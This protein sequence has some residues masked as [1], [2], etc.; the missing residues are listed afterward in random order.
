MDPI[1]KKISKV[2]IV[3][4]NLK[5]TLEQ[6]YY[7]YGIGGWNI[8]EQNPCSMKGQVIYGIKA[9]YSA[10][11]AH[12]KIGD[13]V[14][15]LIEPSD[16]NSIYAQFLQKY[17]EGIHHLG[18]EV[19][20][21][22]KTLK[23]FENNNLK[24]T[25]S[26]YWG[27]L[28]S[29]FFN[30]KEDLKHTVE[31]YNIS[32]DFKYPKPV[33]RYPDNSI[34]DASIKPMFKEV[35]Q[36]GLAVLDIKQTART[37]NDKYGIGPWELYKYFSPKAKDMQ[38]GE[39]NINNQKF[40]T[41]A[42]MIDKIEVELVEPEQGKTVYADYINIYGEGVQHISFIYNCSFNEAIEFHKNNGQIIKQSGSINNAI[43]AYFD[44]EKDL[45]F[46]SEYVYVPQDFKMPSS[47][48]SYPG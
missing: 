46:I 26:S 39:L 45:K 24:V 21:I 11:I 29:V 13:T 38:Y 8:W 22:D 35:R 19:E 18:Y 10:Y 23:F 41:G 47:D 15:E 20:D 36:I 16:D 48:Y 37:Y 9:G 27:D 17:G 14:W 31:I 32:K 42:A 12:S 5:K 34:K 1:L 43:Y 3:V 25:Q 4:R 33:S 2:G 7:M 40:T 28:K 30:T 6:Y 44:T